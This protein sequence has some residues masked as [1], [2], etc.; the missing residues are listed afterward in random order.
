MTLEAFIFNS[1][2][3]RTAVQRLGLPPS[4]FVVAVPGADRLAASLEPDVIRARAARPG[5]LRV[6][7]LGNLIPRKGL[8]TL[9]EAVAL[10]PPDAVELIVVGSPEVDPAHA[11]RVRRRVAVLRRGQTTRFLG[12][13]D[14]SALT[15]V[16][17][18]AHV[19]AVPSAYEG[20]GMAY[21]EGM[22]FGLPAIAG[23][24]GGA[25]EF[26][27]SAENGFLVDPADAAALAVHLASLHADRARLARMGLAARETFLAAPT[28]EQTGAA[29]GA[30][31]S[32]LTRPPDAEIEAVLSSAD[33]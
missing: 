12:V 3:T 20:Y 17:A 21:L 2:A 9:I 26:V 24:D 15:R 16:M 25:A 1:R 10:V 29:I 33:R 14:G 30:F 23:A 22:G 7:F 6:L 32:D 8:L 28:W 13:L 27:R 5:P 18:E 4:P 31:L 11:R 19:L